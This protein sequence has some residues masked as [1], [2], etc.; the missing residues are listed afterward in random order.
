MFPEILEPSN[1]VVKMALNISESAVPRGI[2]GVKNA[3]DEALNRD[4]VVILPPQDVQR[5]LELVRLLGLEHRS[6][7]SF[8]GKT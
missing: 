4:R 3:I 6:N 2:V 1:K 8:E 5:T 7:P